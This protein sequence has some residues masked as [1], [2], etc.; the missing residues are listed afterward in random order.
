MITCSTTNKRQID[1]LIDPKSRAKTKFSDRRRNKKFDFSLIKLNNGHYLI[2][3]S[4]PR[5]RGIILF[6]FILF[7][8]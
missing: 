3:F 2:I 5:N 7:I 8:N 1:R 6:Y 4:T